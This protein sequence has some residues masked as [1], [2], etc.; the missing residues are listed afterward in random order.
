M[1]SAM[2]SQVPLSV[3][4]T[5]KSA[6]E[7]L[8][9][10]DVCKAFGQVQALDGVSLTVNYGEVVALVGD[11]GAGKSTLVKVISGVI[12][13]DQGELYVRGER[14]AIHSPQDAVDRGIRTIFQ[15]LALADN[16]D[17]AENLF[18]GREP[19]RG[20]GPLR[21][22]DFGA[23]R[24]RTTTVLEELG[25]GTI[26]DVGAKVAQLSGGQR[27]TVAVARATLDNCAI[28]L[29]DEPTAS[30]GLREAGNVMQLVLRLRSQGSGMIVI[31]HNMRQ[32]FEVA[33]R[34]VVLHLGRIVA[35]FNKSETSPEAVVKAI[36]GK[37]S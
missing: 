6:G 8:R 15:D 3:P 10:K 24:R 25:I 20:S 35:M 13:P 19:M 4:A 18:L 26:S 32:V 22:V 12:S 31:S 34:I 9:V 14:V 5:A 21:R 23:M 27:Q 30:L 17:V 2:A 1:T 29:L 37:T 33:D 28:L 16:L 36:M 11:N 7:A